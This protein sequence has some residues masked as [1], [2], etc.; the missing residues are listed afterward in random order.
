MSIDEQDG[1]NAAGI[2]FGKAA[3]KPAATT[4]AWL[5]GSLSAQFLAAGGLLMLIAMLVAGYLITELV[6]G[7]AIRH[8]AASTA[9]FM[10]SLV[11]PAAQ[12]LSVSKKLS[13]AAVAKLDALLSDEQFKRRFP[14]LEIWTPDG[15]VA[16]SNTA[17]IIGQRFKQPEGLKRAL[18]GEVAA[19]FTDLSAAEHVIRGIGTRYLEI[20]SPIRQHASGQIIAVAEIHEQ[21]EHLHSDLASLRTSSWAVVAMVTLAIMAGL[22]GI[23]HRG[24]KTI[25]TQRAALA[26]R[27]FEMEEVSRHN[28]LL[29]ERSQRASARVTELNEQFIRTLGADLHDGPAQL[30]GFSILKIDEIRK[31]TGPAATEKLLQ[32]MQSALDEAMREIRSIAK[33]LL[34]PEIAEL[35]LHEVISRAV[36]AHE[37]RT[38]SQVA[39]A[40][41]EVRAP[42]SDAVKICV[43]RFVQEGLNNAYRHGGGIGQEVGNLIDGF[44]LRVWVLDRGSNQIASSDWATKGGMGLYGLRE[45][46]ESLGGSLTVEAERDAGTRIQMTLDLSGGLLLG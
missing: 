17:Q 12:E 37:V 30:I 4:G 8:K 27:V 13:G 11:G 35:P 36:R 20:Y 18:G 19:A 24:S 15:V 40:T 29:K 41:A 22:F 7:G 6:T 42:V 23:V 46:V 32:P 38:S 14:Y 5:P 25:E 9:L 1:R 2:S 31:S 34:L 26:R 28:R 10:E 45:R 16:Y 3:Q 43:F 44:A 33:G 21:T 39:L